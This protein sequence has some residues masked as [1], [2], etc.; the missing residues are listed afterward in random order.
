MLSTYKFIEI[1]H[2]CAR[3]A[4]HQAASG[5]IEQPNSTPTLSPP[6]HLVNCDVIGKTLFFKVT[7]SLSTEHTLSAFSDVPR[8][9]MDRI[10]VCILVRRNDEIGKLFTLSFLEGGCFGSLAKPP[11]PKDS[12]STATFSSDGVI[13]FRSSPLQC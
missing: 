7:A 9:W 1:F 13:C 11:N 8:S 2:V 5:P 4:T 12:F 6:T 3:S 10:Q